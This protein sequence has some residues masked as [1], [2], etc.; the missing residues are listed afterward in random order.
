MRVGRAAW[1]LLTSVNFAV[2]QIIFLA[3][4]GV[5]GMTI[6][7][8]PSFAFRSLGDYQAEMAR[9]RAIY[10]P[11]IGPGAVGLLEQLGA[12]AVFTS[13]WFSGALAVLVIS[14]VVCTLDRTPR[15]WRHAAHVRVIQPGPFFDPEL[16]DRARVPGGPAADVVG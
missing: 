12:F 16:P 13:P 5:V 8:L 2:A 7:Q 15:L 14:I 9:L 6:R 11:A 3:L 4:L 10:E 1:G